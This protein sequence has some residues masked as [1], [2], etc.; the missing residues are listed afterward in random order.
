MSRTITFNAIELSS[1]SEAIQ[2]VD[3]GPEYTHP[4]AVSLGGSYY[5]MEKAEA[6]RLAAEGVEFAYLFDHE[7]PDGEH[8]LISVPVNDD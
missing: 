7:M 4:T 5:V 6:E 8:R 3:C 2:Y 1:A